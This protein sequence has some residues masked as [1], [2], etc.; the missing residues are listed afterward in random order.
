MAPRVRHVRHGCFADI[1]VL[2]ALEQNNLQAMLSVLQR[3][4]TTWHP[5]VNYAKCEAVCM[6]PAA[7]GDAAAWPPLIVPAASEAIAWVPQACYLGFMTAE[8]PS[9]TPH[10]HRCLATV[11]KAKELL[12]ALHC[13]GSMRT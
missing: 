8:D 3:V 4:A 2:L 6:Q 13:P 1:L 11:G 12:P 5:Q 9:W 10:L 7:G